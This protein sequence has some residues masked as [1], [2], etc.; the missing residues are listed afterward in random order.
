MEGSGSIPVTANAPPAGK[1]FDKWTG[2]TDYVSAIYSMVAY[3][4]LPTNP[5][6][7]T[8]TATYKN[9]TLQANAIDGVFS[10]QT[11]DLIVVGGQ[12][13]GSYAGGTVVE[14]SANTPAAGKVFSGWTGDDLTGIYSVYSRTTMFTM[15]ENTVM[16]TATYVDES[17][18][19]YTLTINGGTGTGSY[20]AGTQIPI[21]AAALPPTDTKIFDKWTGDVMY[22]DDPYNENA[23]VTM[24]G[25]HIILTANYAYPQSFGFLVAF[26]SVVQLETQDVAPTV[27]TYD[28]RTKAKAYTVINKGTASP[29]VIVS[30]NFGSI[31]C[32]WNKK[33]LLLK[34]SLKP[35]AQ[36]WEAYLAVNPIAPKEYTMNVITG[37]TNHASNQNI[38]LVPPEIWN[39]SD[40]STQQQVSSGSPNQQLVLRGM[41][42]GRNTPTI[43]LEYTSSGNSTIKALRCKV[44]SNMNISNEF[45]EIIILLPKKFKWTTP[46]QHN[47]VL[48]NGVGISTIEFF[49][50]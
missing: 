16:I 46:G 35:K 18:D 31:Q 3:V 27:T 13:S 2:D 8:I 32:Q 14:V 12:G 28:A 19:T 42:F 15:P 17:A 39:V 34:K 25:K 38:T 45:G 48:E 50:N 24:A 9:A 11:Y 43:S 10:A 7:V 41:Y 21:V 30:P 40:Q 49:T 22:L 44:I 33:V 26:G 6:S 5:L 29:K 36:T 4:T 23:V 1:I 20:T 47:I 37:G